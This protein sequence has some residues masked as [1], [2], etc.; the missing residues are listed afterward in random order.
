MSSAE[1]SCAPNGLWSVVWIENTT[2]GGLAQG[3]P[4]GW[5]TSGGEKGTTLLPQALAPNASAGIQRVDKRTQS[6]TAW[7]GSIR[8]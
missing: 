3:T 5:Q 6:C 1:E 7:I 4:I 8:S 2:G